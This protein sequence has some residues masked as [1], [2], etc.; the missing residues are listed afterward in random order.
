MLAIVASSSSLRQRSLSLLLLLLLAAVPFR[1]AAVATSAPDRAGTLSLPSGT[2][3]HALFLALDQD[4]DRRITDA[5]YR[6][7]FAAADVDGDG[8]VSELEL[9][10]AWTNASVIARAAPRHDLNADRLVTLHE[11]LQTERKV[12][13]SERRRGGLRGIVNLLERLGL[14]RSNKSNS[15]SG[16]NNNNNNNNNNN[17]NVA[18]KFNISDDQR[19]HA[20]IPHSNSFHTKTLPT[21]NGKKKKQHSA[22]ERSQWEREIESL[23]Q[24]R[25]TAEG[26]G[27]TRPRRKRNTAVGSSRPH[28][29]EN[30][31]NVNPVFTAYARRFNVSDE[32]ILFLLHDF[33][34][35]GFIT[36]QEWMAYVSGR[37]DGVT[38]KEFGR[39]LLAARR[40]VRLFMDL[41]GGRDGYLSGLE[42]LQAVARKPIF[43]TLRKPER[44]EIDLEWSTTTM[45][46]YNISVE[47]LIFIM[48]DGGN[49]AIV[50][51]REY[52]FSFVTIDADGNG[53]LSRHEMNRAFR[54]VR[55]LTRDFVRLDRDG[56]GRISA[57]EF[58][59]G[60]AVDS[61]T[62][63]NYS[64]QW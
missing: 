13:H 40:L 61:T 53:Q 51:Q 55:A 48:F 32:R 19:L 52:A 3:L 33:D 22:Q 1:G 58:L 37:E 60:C 54:L 45:G 25:Q 57:R 42:I 27:S 28:A 34:Q 11:L 14:Y 26:T 18:E 8:L 31:E 44:N 59:I 39:G 47:D 35:N 49:D 9:V 2:H 20:L 36:E 41:D 16:S 46:K 5:E 24:R 10:D 12:G 23:I 17:S 4:D 62:T 30:A 6:R 38:E 15:K 43:D 21:S 7:Y 63:H 29:V 50:S 64:A 56:D